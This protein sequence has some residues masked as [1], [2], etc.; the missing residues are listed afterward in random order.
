MA[1]RPTSR[2]PIIL[3]W[4]SRFTSGS[5]RFPSCRSVKCGDGRVDGFR[6]SS[7]PLAH[8]QVIR[9][10]RRRG[11]EAQTCASHTQDLIFRRV[12]RH[13]SKRPK[14]GKYELKPTFPS[15]PNQPFGTLGKCKNLSKM[16]LGTLGPH[17]SPPLPLPATSAQ[18]WHDHAGQFFFRFR[19]QK[20]LISNAFLQE[21]RIAFGRLSR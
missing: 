14:P 15:V 6:G 9:N 13:T 11:H 8:C 20:V 16:R 12:F 10:C 21:A 17:F 18:W 4:G 5:Y 1:G 3:T 7:M 19:F 2:N